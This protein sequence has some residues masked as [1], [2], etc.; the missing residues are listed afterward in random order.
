MEEHGPI[1]IALHGSITLDTMWI[2]CVI[3]GPAPAITRLGISPYQWGTECLSGDVKA[4]PATSFPQSIGMVML[5]NKVYYVHS[6]HNCVQA[7]SFNYDMLYKVARAISDEVRAKV[8]I[9]DDDII[10]TCVLVVLILLRI[11]L[12]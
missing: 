1:V 7:A 2:M 6:L 9:I 10:M 4:G 12:L 3:A 11:I 8:I 5:I